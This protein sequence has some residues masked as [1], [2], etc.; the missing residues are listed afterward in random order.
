MTIGIVGGGQL[1][2]M[3]ALAG[4][5]LGLDF[6]FLDRS[7]DTPGGQVAPS[8]VGDFTD[9]RLLRTL[10]ARSEVI[11]FDWENISVES[12]RA[13]G[14]SAKIAPPLAALAVSQDRIA[15]KR[16]FARYTHHPLCRSRLACE[17]RARTT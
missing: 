13:L 15:E 9:K 1:G 2:R 16:L 7:N 5:P 3:L 4:Y 12:L 6:L 11:T 8:L 17:P 14:R 10:A